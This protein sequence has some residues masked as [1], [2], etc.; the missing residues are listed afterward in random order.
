MKIR[1]IDV[2]DIVAWMSYPKVRKIVHFLLFKG[3]FS[4][5]FLIFTFNWVSLARTWH[6]VTFKFSSFKWA[7]FTGV[8][9]APLS[10]C[11]GSLYVLEVFRSPWSSTWSLQQMANIILSV[12][13]RLWF[14][15]FYRVIFKVIFTLQRML[16]GINLVFLSKIPVIFH[17]WDFV[18][19]YATCDF[20]KFYE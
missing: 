8:Y 10:A 16:L 19:F 5:C 13:H 17:H 3:L 6:F 15:Y 18:I 4:C 1:S 11:L 7:W 9:F 14:W 2:K 20:I 12:A